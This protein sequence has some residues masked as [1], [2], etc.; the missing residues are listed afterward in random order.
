[1]TRRLLL[2]PLA[3]SLLVLLPAPFLARLC[4]GHSP[5][6][7]DLVNLPAWERQLPAPAPACRLFRLTPPPPGT[8]QVPDNPWVAALL[9][10]DE[11]RLLA[12]AEHP[13]RGDAG[14][15]GAWLE[16]ACAWGRAGAALGDKQDR[17]ATRLMAAQADNGTWG[18]KPD[19][20]GWTPDEARA[21]CLCLRGLLA[22]YGLTRRPAAGYGALLAGSGT[23]AIPAGICDAPQVYPLA[24][25]YQATGDPRFLAAARRLAPRADGLG[26]CAL[27]EATGEAAPLQAARLAW[28]RDPRDPGLTSELLL[29]TG[30]PCYAAALDRLPPSGPELAHAA[31]TRAPQGVSV[32]TD[33][34]AS[35]AFHGVR[36]AQVGGRANRT[37]IVT[38]ASPTAFTL[39]VFLPTD[40]PARV[41]VNGVAQAALTPPRGYAVLVRR[42]RSGDVVRVA[43]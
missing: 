11:N 3:L 43:G 23:V 33:R 15:P 13:G 4:R 31:W 26:L 38:A 7:F 5:S 40:A 36:L 42:W 19:A 41:W 6:R 12:G 34:T 14:R 22:Y 16:A 39:R 28:L 20:L 8:I 25:L 21:Q 29:L 9:R 35:A 1:M 17:V 2:R 10:A 18:R 37:I 32:N 27:Y 24:R 30:Q